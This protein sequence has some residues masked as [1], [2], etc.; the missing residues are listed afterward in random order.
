MCRLIFIIF[1]TGI[2]IYTQAQNNIS[3]RIDMNTPVELGL[4]EVSSGDRIILRGS[5]NNWQ[6]DNYVLNDQDGDHIY[7]GT[8]MIEGDPGTV[9]EYKFIIL[10]A[11][12]KALWEKYPDPENPPNGN[13]TFTLDTVFHEPELAIYHFDKYYLG[14]VGKEVLFSVEEMQQD[15]NR[16]RQ[17]L[18]KEHCCLYEYTSKEISDSLFQHQYDLITTPLHP[19]EFYNILS[20]ITATIGCMHTAVWMPGGYWDMQPDNLFPLRVKLIEDYV[21]VAGSYNDTLQVPVGSIILEI[22]GRPVHEIIEEMRNNISADALNINFINSQIEKR[23]PM[24]YA[25]RYG[26]PEEYTITYALPGRKTRLTTELIPADIQSVRAVVFKNFNHPPLF[27]ELL[28]DE[29]TAVLTIP[30]FIYYD[31]VD[32]FTNFLDSSFSIISEKKIRNLIL[33]LRGNDGGDPFCAVP[34]LSY[35]EHEPVPY[36]AEPYGRYS[37]FAQPIPMADNHFTGNL[38]TL[39]DGYCGSTNGHFCALLKYHKI[40]KIV[41]TPSGATYKCNA[42]RDTEITLEHSRIILTFGRSTF[43]AAVNGMDKS[44]PIMPDYPV[45][46][47]YKDFINGKDTC[48]ETAMKLIHS[49]N[50]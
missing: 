3:F 28:E 21:V 6:G 12:G 4:L 17:V 11:G 47:T 5:F 35:L 41:G 24:I 18:E 22:N 9:V 37:E 26:F 44:K 14:L 31:R 16:M 34:L 29:N 1:F 43:A 23:F 7:S 30:T 13:R 32:Y 49:L 8:F 36:F 2:S 50:D 19:H 20:P 48:L 45:Q 15:F 27:L 40:G 46:L 42:G 39:L 33:D 38:F 10:K 25:R